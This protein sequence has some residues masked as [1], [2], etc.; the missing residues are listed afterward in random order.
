[1]DFRAAL[2]AFRFEFRRTLTP[3]RMIFGAGLAMFPVAIVL[4]IKYV[5]HLLGGRGQPVT[6][7]NWV[8]QLSLMIPGVVCVMGLLLWAT[9]L[10]HAELEGRTWVYL[11]VRPK[12]KG[13]VLLGK[14]LAAVAWTALTGWVSLTI[15]LAILQPPEGLRLWLVLAVMVGLSCMTFGALYTLFGVLALRR[16]MV[17]AVGYTFLL[18][19]LVAFF[20][21]AMINRLT[22]GYHLRSLVA[23]WLPGYMVPRPSQMQMTVF[24][25]DAPGWVHVLTL[26]GATAALL[27]ASVLILRQRELVKPEEG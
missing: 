2:A 24:Y 11:A 15:C 18:E 16:A 3:A 22:I 8:W 26:M 17:A 4:L 1:M 23:Q 21:P 25:G 20:V 13:S 12:A 7:D 5:E 14:Y 19:G 9:P 6:I 27:L 10:V